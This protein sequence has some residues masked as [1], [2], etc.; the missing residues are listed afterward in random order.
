MTPE[1]YTA[2]KAR[3]E[4][5]TPVVLIGV[6]ISKHNAEFLEHAKGDMAALLAEIERLREADRWIPAEEKPPKGLKR[7]LVYNSYK[8]EIAIDEDARFCLHVDV[9]H[10]RPLPE[11]PKEVEG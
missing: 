6:P 2:I 4:A 9:T 1:E 10:W 7:V 5:A 3:C 11:P 8:R